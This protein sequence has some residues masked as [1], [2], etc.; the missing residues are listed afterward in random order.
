MTGSPVKVLEVVSIPC[1]GQTAKILLS[2]KPYFTDTSCIHS[3][4]PLISV[5]HFNSALSL[6][7]Y[8]LHVH[9]L[10][11]DISGNG[12]M[13]WAYSVVGAGSSSGQNNVRVWP[14]HFL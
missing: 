7:E 8:M 5:I 2:P 13:Y 12:S 4:I 6:T 3:F 10:L 1:L 11:Q 14:G 9:C